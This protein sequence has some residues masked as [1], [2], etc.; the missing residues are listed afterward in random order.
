VLLAVNVTVLVPTA[1]FG[2]NEALTPDPSPEAD[3]VTLPVNP[4]AGVTVIV[5]FPEE[6][7]LMLTLLGEA[8][9]VK[10]PDT[11]ALTV[12]VTVVVCVI[13]PPLAVTAME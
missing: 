4:F 8:D 3:N 9:S 2:L 5:D 13:L 12:S 6:D 10:L 7:R 1:G 11:A